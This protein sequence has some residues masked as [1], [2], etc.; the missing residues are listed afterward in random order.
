VIGVV[1][2]E[3]EPFLPLRVYGIAD[4]SAFVQALLDTGFSG[5]LMLPFETID[6]LGLRPITTS[7]LVLGDGSSVQ[8]PVFDA[9]VEWQGRTRRIDVYACERDAVIG[10]SLLRGSDI[11]LDAVPDGQVNVV[12]LP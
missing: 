4:R 2:S 9:V 3:L 12:P 10:M 6:Y 7:R 1:S 8:M 11:D 5:D